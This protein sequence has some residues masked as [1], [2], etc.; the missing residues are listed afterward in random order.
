VAASPPSEEPSSQSFER[1]TPA[2]SKPYRPRVKRP[3]LT[4]F[5]VLCVRILDVIKRGSGGTVTCSQ[6]RRAL[7]AHR[8][9]EVYEKAF[10]TLISRRIIKVQKEA[11]TRRQL[12]ILLQIP[13]KYVLTRPKP[14][15][16]HK[17]R[18]RGQTLWFQDLMAEQELED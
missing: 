16:H 17:P 7:N 1:T 14:K 11:G 15:R 3:D 12:V 6:V 4:A 10:Q 5:D 2:A 13:P 18:S 8:Y 9:K